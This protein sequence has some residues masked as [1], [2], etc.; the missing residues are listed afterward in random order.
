MIK[1]GIFKATSKEVGNTAVEA[2]PEKPKTSPVPS[3]DRENPT[4]KELLNLYRQDHL[5]MV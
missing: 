2:K 4:Y 1:T 5:T 3:K